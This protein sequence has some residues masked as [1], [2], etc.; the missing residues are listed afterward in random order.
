MIEQFEQA[1]TTDNITVAKFSA[2]D[3][4]SATKRQKK[5]FKFKEREE[6]GKK[7]NKINPRFIALSMVK[8]KFTPLG[9]ENSSRQGLNIRT[10][11][12]IQKGSQEE[13]QRSEHLGERSFPSKCQ[14]SKV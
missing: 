14:V 7:R 10:I 11:I 13:V 4:D 3:E 1:D 12:N 2:S 8:I 6:N 5:R 9:S